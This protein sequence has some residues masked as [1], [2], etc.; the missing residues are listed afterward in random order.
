VNIRGASHLIQAVSVVVL[1]LPMGL[2][3]ARTGKLPVPSVEVVWSAPPG[4]YRPSFQ[5]E[6]RQ[7]MLVVSPLNF[8]ADPL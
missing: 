6:E 3:V 2:A 8:V 1:G 7:L 5:W 4:A